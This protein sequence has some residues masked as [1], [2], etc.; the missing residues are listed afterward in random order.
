[1]TD[2]EKDTDPPAYDWEADAMLEWH[3]GVPLKHIARKHGVAYPRLKQY[4][5]RTL[6]YGHNQQQEISI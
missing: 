2:T 5:R 6:A 4:I 1:M 3:L